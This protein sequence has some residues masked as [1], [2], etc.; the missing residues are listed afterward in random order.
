MPVCLSACVCVRVGV[1]SQTTHTHTHTHTPAV[2]P[3]ERFASQLQTIK[4]MGF[5]DEESILQ[6]LVATNGNI[7]AAVDRLLS[8]M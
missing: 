6:A 7:N 2:P 8:S 3:R 4:D 1:V 5:Y